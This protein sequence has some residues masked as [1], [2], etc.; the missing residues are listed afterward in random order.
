[1]RKK[2]SL[3]SLACLPLLACGGDDANSK[4]VT[5]IDAKTFL[6]APP[7]AGCKA[8]STYAAASL[9]SG[10]YAGD[11]PAGG[12][13]FPEHSQEVQA[14]LAHTGSGTGSADTVD[15]MDMLLVQGGSGMF[16]AGIN[17]GT[18]TIDPTMD[19]TLQIVLW[20]AL[21]GNTTSIPAAYLAS[22]QYLAFSG[23]LTLTAEGAAGSAMT[24]TL[25]SLDFVH[26]NLA[27]NQFTAANDD[28]SGGSCESM[29]SSISF[30][31]QLKAV[32][33]TF[34]GQEVGPPVAGGKIHH[35]ILSRRHQ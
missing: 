23:S 21:P 25:S 6:D 16:A 33:P 31:K 13:M 14:V 12:A 5:V 28:G 29:A 1:M 20:P 27:N 19:N 4:K 17:A 10:V 15:L 9:G 2:L 35:F 11:T 3:L 24:G 7:A 32:A 34:Q 30:S 18:Y 22:E 26:V 8:P